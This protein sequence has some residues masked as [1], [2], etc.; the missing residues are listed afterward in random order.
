MY[1]YGFNGKESED[2]L[3]G[4][5]ISY[6]FGAKI[7]DPRSGRWLAVD[8]L[9]SHSNRKVALFGDVELPYQVH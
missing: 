7:Y 1:R 4:P 3:K 8:P 6:D 5:G 2:E 9:A